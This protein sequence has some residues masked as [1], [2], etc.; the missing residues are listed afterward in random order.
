MPAT[1]A[2]VTYTM[3]LSDLIDIADGA[4]ELDGL[5]MFLVDQP[6]QMERVAERVARMHDIVER[7]AGQDAARIYADDDGSAP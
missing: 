2:P 1:D 3:T 6:D 5:R 4:A 7:A